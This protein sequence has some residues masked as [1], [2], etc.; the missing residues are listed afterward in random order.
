MKR[1][2]FS[3]AVLALAGISARA[4][5]VPPAIIALTDTGCTTA[6]PCTAQIYRASG[7][8]PTDGTIASGTELISTEAPLSSTVTAET[9]TYSDST[10]AASTT[11]CYYATVTYSSGGGPS[12]NSQQ[13]SYTTP[14]VQPPPAPTITSIT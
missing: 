14:A 8:C 10:V 3:L 4:Q 11:Y 5:T 2:L 6:A 12:P 13:L 9:W 1:I 7:A